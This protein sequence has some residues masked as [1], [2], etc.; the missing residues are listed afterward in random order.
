MAYVGWDGGSISGCEPNWSP[1]AQSWTSTPRVVYLTAKVHMR[2]MGNRLWHRKGKRMQISEYGVG[3][4][5]GGGRRDPSS[6][7][8]GKMIFARDIQFKNNI[9]KHF[10]TLTLTRASVVSRGRNDG[11]ICS[12]PDNVSSIESL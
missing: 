2:P 5:K 11:H 4:G 9:S 1:C 6:T 10:P 8:A 12:I 3:R 7:C